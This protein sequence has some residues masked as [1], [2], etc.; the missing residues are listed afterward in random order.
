MSRILPSFV[1]LIRF[2]APYLPSRQPLRLIPRFV[3]AGVLGAGAVSLVGLAGCEKKPPELAPTKPPEVL[4]AKAFRQEIQDFEDF[5]GR[6]EAYQMTEI[7]ARVSGYLEGVHFKDG[8]DVQEGTVVAEIDPRIYQATVNKM[9]ASVLQAEAHLKRL[10]SEMKRAER[11]ASLKTITQE[12]YEKAA[13]DRSEALAQ[14]EGAKAELALANL[15]LTFSK[16]TA[17]QTGRIG[18]RMVDPGNLIKA[19][20][21]IL[22]TIVTLDPIYASFDI[23]ERTLLRLRRLVRE[24]KMKSA[25]ENEVTVQVGLADEEGFSMEGIIDFVDITLH[26]GTGA[27]R[28]RAIMKNPK[29]ILSPGL[30]VRIRLPVGNPHDGWMIPEEAMGTDQGNKIIY[31]LNDKDE[32]ISRRVKQGV[33]QGVNREI[34]EGLG[35][36]ERV[37]VSGIQRVRP[38]V[39]VT[40]RNAPD[41]PQGNYDLKDKAKAEGTAK[42][43][44]PTSTE[45]PGN[46]AAKGKESTST[47]NADGAGKGT[48]S[49]SKEGNAPASGKE[50]AVPAKTN[51]A[52]PAKNKGA[53]K[54]EKLAPISTGDRPK[55]S[56]RTPNMGASYK[57]GFSP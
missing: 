29:K 54:T 27:L 40:P 52:E 39:K 44:T 25:R 6:T 11:L 46:D 42:T 7:R 16:V 9:S 2:F 49:A 56:G 36:E 34:V 45:P 38:G 35:P 15:N 12:E 5:T 4:V 41:Q 14:V 13:G 33:L 32:V 28:V 1:S 19:D 24:G 10:T 18:R 26:P 43:E 30:F 51:P 48:T 8:A 31:V 53:S 3:A 50:A 57:R 55:G 21:T 37:I 23:D 20:D 17:P 22:A 47:K